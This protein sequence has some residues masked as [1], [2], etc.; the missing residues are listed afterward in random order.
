LSLPMAIGVEFRRHP[1]FSDYAVGDNGSVWNDTYGYWR[2]RRLQFCRH[3]LFISLW[4]NKRTYSRFVHRLVLEAFV[5]PCPEGMECCHYDGNPLNNH[6]GNLRWDTHKNNEADKRRHGTLSVGEKCNH[7]KITAD[8]VQQIKIDYA[9]GSFT[10]QQLAEKYGVGKG[11]I[12]DIIRCKTWKH[13]LE[14]SEKQIYYSGKNKEHKRG[15]RNGNSK[16]T[17]NDVRE[18]R[19]LYSEGFERVNLAAM[20]CVTLDSI[21]KIVRRKSWKHVA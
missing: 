17:E 12:S 10:Q 5:G 11:V 18:I 8:Q 14:E 20:F 16:L 7:N 1:E 6:L 21:A 19:H 3:H 9:S 13:L 15:E 4:I 2:E